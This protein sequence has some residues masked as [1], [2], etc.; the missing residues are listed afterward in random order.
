MLLT[1][2]QVGSTDNEKRELLFKC[3]W[4]TEYC[5]QF[6]PSGAVHKT[7]LLL[8]IHFT[9]TN[10][11]HRQC[12]PVLKQLYTSNKAANFTLCYCRKPG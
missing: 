11:V 8:H 7:E 5:G 3:I 2:N 4:S 10:N 6:E 1:D 9:A 12:H